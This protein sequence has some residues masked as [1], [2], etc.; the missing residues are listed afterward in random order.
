MDLGALWQGFTNPPDDARPRVWWHWMDGNVD[1]DGIRLDLEWLHRVGVRG[2]QMF[3]GGMGTPQVVPELV[4]SGSAEW[5]E[6]VRVAATTAR[7]L[8]LEF[9]VAT[10]AG[11]SAAGGPWIEPADA[12]KKIVWS[13]T[14]VTGGGPVEQ[15][16]APLPDVAG[17][18]QDC[19]RWGADPGANR[20]VVDWITVA[21]PAGQVPTALVPAAVHGSAPLGVWAGLVD[22]SFAGAVSLPRDPDGPSSAW[23]EQVFDEPVEVAAVTIGLPG[24]LG[25][26]SAPPPDVVLEVVDDGRRRVV[27]EL[28]E[29]V[30]PAAKAV[31][32]RSATF[33][34]VRARRFRLTL[35]GASA[36]DALP[37]LAEGVT[38]PPVLRR[39]SEFLVSEFVL[40][41]GGRVH[42]AELKAGFAAA[43]DYYA[44]DTAPAAGTVAIDPARVVDVTA[45]VDEHGV[46]CW[47]APE[48]RWLVL[49]FGASLTGATNG[50]APPEA[51]GL[52]VDKLDGAKVRRYLDT[53]LS[54]FT[55]VPL[56]GL[57][58]DS[59]EAGPQT[60][61]DGLHERFAELRGYDPM[62]WLPAIAGY[63]V[64]DPSR[65]D[66]FL[67]DH[68]RVLA[69][70][71]AGE[72]YGTLAEVAHARGLRYYAE[73]LEDHRPQLGDDLAMR[74]HADVPMGA[75]WVF[76]PGTGRPAPTYVADLK[77]ASSVAHVH[78]K[79][80]TGA[81][82]MTAFHRPWSDTPRRLKH[83]ADLELAL[84]VTR[85][86]IHTSPHQPAGAPPPGIGLSPHLGQAFVRTEPWA[87]LAGAWVD[88]L[89]RCSWLLNQGA[90]A[91][92]VAVFVGEEAPV[93]ALYGTEPYRD[94]PAGLDFDF[95][96]L[97]ALER[98]CTVADG[99]V[100]AGPVRYRV[101][102]LAGSSRRMTL[103]ALRRVSELVAAG[104]TVVGR[105]PIGSPSLADDDAAHASLC[106]RL[107]APGGGV[108]DLDLPA[109]L[110]DLG[111]WPT[112]AVDGADLLR[113]GRRT[114]TAELVFL[115]N[116]EPVPVT[117][118]VTGTS[119]V[120]WHPVTLRR[121]ALPE[122]T[123]GHRLSLPALGSVFLVAGGP[124][125]PARDEPAAA[126]SCDGEWRLTL[127]GVL[128]TVLRDGPRPWTELGRAAAAFAG[129]GTYTTAI[130]VDPGLLDRHAAVLE[131]ADIGDIAR[132]RI[133]GSDCGVVWTPPF[134]LE[135]GDALRPGRNTV[136][137]AVA[138]AWLN[139]LIAEAAA[140]TGELFGPAAQVYAPDAPV[141]TAGLSGP[142]SVQL[143]RRS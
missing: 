129:T 31:P 38:L 8:G 65:S 78:G 71:L 16:L 133:N 113:I 120:A 49:R 53:Y 77:G 114:A 75:M 54:R 5:R 115:A 130:D 67:W 63:V 139:R 104:A 52:E 119:G 60:Y 64:G 95:V 142:V 14:P 143:F 118:T 127:P 90:P 136:E 87:D 40:W 125:E 51:T 47:D 23:L 94:V 108:H 76:D 72:F 1:P 128:D 39:A 61:T 2:V 100:V 103:R 135:V 12:M 70:L 35:S 107:W 19:P 141:R 140:P 106:D 69:D 42:R 37:R 137:V 34:P 101:L 50:P 81:E 9:T 57:L 29:V 134:R 74:S 11:W 117:A 92:D 10:S 36:A 97:D 93:T 85:F 4:R 111:V 102:H 99:A 86:C 18:Y 13:E 80:F 122:V 33:E 48:G 21:V 6:A 105:R 25:F 27:A 45:H 123:G 20:Y 73:A 26:G 79:A 55:G 91:V 121:E 112:L 98:R 84:G 15:P 24:P 82:S 44:V 7:R 89:A 62:P 17:P 56:D 116:P 126:I 58:S 32:V 22:G 88:Y 110:R 59:I 131:C 83:V 138:N 41:T 124:A 46:L 3:D 66:R 43:P 30:E 68:R 132:V 109:A 28:P 96:D